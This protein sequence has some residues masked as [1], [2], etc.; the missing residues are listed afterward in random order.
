MLRGE[1]LVLGRVTSFSKQPETFISKHHHSG[2]AFFF[3]K[4]TNSASCN[5]SG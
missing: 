4:I 2:D 1:G 3:L 5:L